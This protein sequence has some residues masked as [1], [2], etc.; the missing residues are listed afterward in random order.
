MLLEGLLYRADFDQYVV[1]SEMCLNESIMQYLAAYNQRSDPAINNDALLSSWLKI[2]EL[3]LCELDDV[4][5]HKRAT[6]AVLSRHCVARLA[7]DL[8]L[9]CAHQLE[10]PEIDFK[11]TL[12]LPVP[13]VLLHR[14]IEMEEL[15]QSEMKSRKNDSP[16]DPAP[17]DHLENEE[18]DE[19][20]DGL[21]C[22]T[23]FL[24]SAHDLLGKRSWCMLKD[25]FF[26]IYLLEVG[27][28]LPR[29]S[30]SGKLLSTVI[31]YRYLYVNCELATMRTSA[32][33]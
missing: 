15:R 5:R 16:V 20:E 32:R 25:G 7:E 22:S 24:L 9:L 29:I 6:L 28:L 2:V 10:V 33:S 23:L 17:T 4:L 8:V 11:I 13:W 12:H 26:V 18:E 30:I 1:W 3:I 14:I 31:I 27:S 21:P 19:E